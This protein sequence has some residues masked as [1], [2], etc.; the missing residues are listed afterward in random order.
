M[1]EFTDKVSVLAGELITSQQFH[2]RK[3]GYTELAN[4]SEDK[5]VDQDGIMTRAWHP[6]CQDCGG[7][8]RP[9]ASISRTLLDIARHV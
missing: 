5:E 6:I 8:L 2:C 3:C 9:L 7:I 4:W 1:E